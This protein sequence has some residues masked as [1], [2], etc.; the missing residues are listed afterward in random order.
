M[1]YDAEVVG[2]VGDV[3]HESLDRPAA[4]EVFLPYAQSGF[5]ALTLVARTAP[6][7]PGTLQAIKE[8]I[9]AVDPLQSIFNS[10]RLDQL[11]AKTLTPGASISSCSA[12]SR[13]RRCCWRPRASTA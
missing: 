12:A 10:S 13:W 1:N 5:Y 9:W 2:I 3:R 11:I 4:A 8:Q 6:G 7:S